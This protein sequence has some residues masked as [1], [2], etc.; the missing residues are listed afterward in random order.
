[1]S[2]WSLADI[3]QLPKRA[4][5]IQYTIFAI[6]VRANVAGSHYMALYD[7]PNKELIGSDLEKFLSNYATHYLTLMSPIA[8]LNFI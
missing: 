7:S 8:R 5:H 3:L 1:M 4:W 2:L 6:L